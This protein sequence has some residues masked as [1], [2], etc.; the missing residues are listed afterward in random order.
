L[1]KYKKGNNSKN[2]GIFIVIS[3]VATS[4]II[5]IFVIKEFTGLNN[6]FFVVTSTSMVP[7]LKIGDIVIASQNPC[8]SKPL[9]S[10]DSRGD[11]QPQSLPS[12]T[13]YFNQLQRDDIIIFRTP[14]NTD[15]N[16]NPRTII[17]RVVQID[18]TNSGMYDNQS[19][20][21]IIKTKGDNN[22]ISFEG[23]DYPITQDNYIGKVMFTLPYQNILII[24]YVIVI[25]AILTRLTVIIGKFVLKKRSEERR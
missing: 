2:N 18:E 9:D 25:I 1:S 16:G 8:N 10:N 24:I 7:T 3:I 17:H 20:D 22:P 4:I 19:H 5:S 23:L 11:S 21:R 13:L 6:P 12:S 15:E 14:N